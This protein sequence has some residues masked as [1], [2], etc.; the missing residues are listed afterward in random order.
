MKNLLSTQAL[1]AIMQSTKDT[2]G[3][4]ETY[5]AAWA[6]VETFVKE[7][8]CSIPGEREEG[9]DRDY[10]KKRVEQLLVHNERQNEEISRKD[11]QTK[12]LKEIIKMLLGVVEKLKED[13]LTMSERMSNLQDEVNAMQ[14][15]FDS[16]Q[17][18]ERHSLAEYIPLL[19]KYPASQNRDVQVLVLFLFKIF[20]KVSDEDRARLH[21]LGMKETPTVQFNKPVYDVNGNSAVSI[22]R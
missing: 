16:W 7:N 18:T 21:N 13:V 10:L 11:N 20:K 4:N 1:L 9:D 12:S 22:G 19:E 5:P 3:I 2:K 15:K 14:A 6:L 8:S 17:Q